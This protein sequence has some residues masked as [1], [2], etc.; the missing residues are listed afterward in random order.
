M[1]AIFVDNIRTVIASPD[2]SGRGNPPLL[3]WESIINHF[4]SPFQGEDQGEGEIG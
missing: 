3:R 4:S 1:S 2:L